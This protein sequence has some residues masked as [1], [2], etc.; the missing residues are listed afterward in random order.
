[1]A[2]IGISADGKASVLG[3]VATARDSHCVTSDGRNQVYVCD[4]GHGRIL[5]FRDALPA[6]R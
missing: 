3:T 6:L 1:M 4:P 2:T 5:V